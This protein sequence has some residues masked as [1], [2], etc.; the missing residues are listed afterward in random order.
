MIDERGRKEGRKEAGLYAAAAGGGGEGGVLQALDHCLRVPEAA[1]L[2]PY[3]EGGGLSLSHPLGAAGTVSYFQP[4]TSISFLTRH[5]ELSVCLDYDLTERAR[6][7]SKV[8]A[9]TRRKG[10][11][12]KEIH[13][14][15]DRLYAH[16][17]RSANKPPLMG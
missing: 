1:R 5:A 8:C 17:T 6:E 16:S 7:K 14:S 15:S 13:P 11:A 12:A 2:L 9:K 3:E 4:A 10:C